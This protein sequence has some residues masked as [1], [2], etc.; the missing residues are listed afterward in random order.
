MTTLKTDPK[1]GNQGTLE[2]GNTLV[3]QSENSAEAVE[4]DFTLTAGFITRLIARLVGDGLH[5]YVL[6]FP[7][8]GITLQVKVSDAAVQDQ[9]SVRL[10]PDCCFM[11]DD[12]I[13]V[14]LREA[15]DMGVDVY[16]FPVPAKNLIRGNNRVLSVV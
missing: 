7:E 15:E 11:G 16:I 10:F 13:P 14:F 8:K 9:P 5:S 2:L 6:A 3:F 1:F 4:I 12:E